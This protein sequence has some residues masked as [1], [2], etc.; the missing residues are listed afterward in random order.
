MAC[1]GLMGWLFGHQ[2]LKNKGGYTYSSDYCYRCGK[3]KGL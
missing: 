1:A 2:F 3:S